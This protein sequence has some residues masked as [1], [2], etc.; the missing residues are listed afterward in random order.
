MQLMATH[1]HIHRRCFV[2]IQSMAM[3]L[4]ILGDVFMRKYYVV[5]E[6]DEK[7]PR[8]GFALANHDDD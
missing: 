6:T 7:N 2:G 1:V 5:F 8:V 3:N 4:W